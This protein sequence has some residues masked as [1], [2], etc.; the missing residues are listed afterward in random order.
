MPVLM[1]IIENEPGTAAAQASTVSSYKRIKTGPRQSVF[2]A[3]ILACLLIL[4][5]TSDSVRSADDT[6]DVDSTVVVLKI[7]NH[8]EWMIPKIES[9]RDTFITRLQKTGRI[10]VLGEIPEQQ[11][12][13]E[14]F[15]IEKGKQLDI[16]KWPAQPAARYII[17]VALQ[18][19]DAEVKREFNFK[20]NVAL[21]KPTVNVRMDFRMIDL[22][23]PDRFKIELRDGASFLSESGTPVTQEFFDKMVK[24]ED[25]IKTIKKDDDPNLKF[26][27]RAI[28]THPPGK[29]VFATGTRASRQETNVTSANFFPEDAGILKNT[30][31]QDTVI[32]A[33]DSAIRRMMDELWPLKIIR[34]DGTDQVY[35]DRGKSAG[36]KTGDVFIVRQ[37]GKVLTDPETGEQRGRTKGKMIAR[38][39]I[40]KTEDANSI[41][42]IEYGESSTDLLGALCHPAPR[43]IKRK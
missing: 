30:L 34:L 7:A 1:P 26:R 31:V 29:I 18:S 28:P 4:V 21:E 2:L 13:D 43:L 23:P 35:V 20:L 3:G 36:I 19:L 41:A 12:V 16:S 6:P 32:V 40:V 27:I 33:M 22:N 11:P 9:L 15:K 38:I 8:T 14:M 39:K 10:N 17:V 24:A 37:A 5:S 42:K 25:R